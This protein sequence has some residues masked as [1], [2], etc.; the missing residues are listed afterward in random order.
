MS[1]VAV[2]RCADY[3]R[4][5]VEESVARLLE[6]LGGAEKFAHPGESLL[7]KPNLL[8]CLLQLL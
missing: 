3:D 8:T 5:R 4:G 2:V 7:L 1:R 6:L